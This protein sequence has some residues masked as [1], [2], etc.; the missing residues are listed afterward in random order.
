MEAVEQRQGQLP[1]CVTV[2]EGAAEQSAKV[3]EVVVVGH[4]L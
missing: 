2:V 1:E 4:L 3:E